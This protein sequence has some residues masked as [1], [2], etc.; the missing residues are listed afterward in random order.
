MMHRRRDA[1]ST[2]DL[3][4]GGGRD[5]V[6]E[7]TQ[8]AL[9]AYYSPA[10]VLSRQPQ[11]QRG[12]IVWD[13]RPS[14]RPGLAS[15][16]RSHAAV[17]AQQRVR[18]HDPAGPQRLRQDPGERGKHRPVTPGQAR[19]RSRPAQYCDLVPEYEYLRVLGRGGPRQQRKPRHH[20][21][22]QPVSQ[23][24]A[25]ERRSWRRRSPRSNR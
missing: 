25:H 17:P 4:D 7:P 6:S 12:E 13:G 14:R 16:G 24:D 2:Q 5:P 1:V 18:G 15:L 23:R 9:D 19:P 22:Q 20:G 3:A 8:L 21:H 10:S 11:D